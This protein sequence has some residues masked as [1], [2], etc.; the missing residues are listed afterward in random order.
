MVEIGHEFLECRVLGLIK[1]AATSATGSL[2][3]INPM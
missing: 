2:L 1:P 3:W